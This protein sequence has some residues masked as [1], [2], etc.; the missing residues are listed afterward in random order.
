MLVPV[1]RDDFREISE[2]AFFGRGLP[3]ELYGTATSTATATDQPKV[4]VR[5]TMLMSN[6]TALL[7]VSELRSAA[8]SVGWVDHLRTSA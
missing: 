6:A 5:A 3:I 8:S 4:R 7:V 2:N 1:L